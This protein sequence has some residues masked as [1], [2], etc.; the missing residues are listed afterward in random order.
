MSAFEL[1]NSNVD[2]EKIL[3][4]KV[5]AQLANLSTEPEPV[6]PAF[7]YTQHGRSAG[8]KKQK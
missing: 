2:L 6:R 1:C 5:E 3:C 8:K 7:R 4:Y